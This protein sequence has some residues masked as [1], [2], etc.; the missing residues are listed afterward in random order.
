MRK[1][2]ERILQQYPR[3]YL[4]DSELEA[5]LDGT[6]NSRYSKVKR[7]LAQGKLQHIRRG[8][9]CITAEVGYLKKTHPFELAQYV[10]GPSLISLES[11]L[12]YYHLIPETVY[13][14]TSVSGKRGK[15]FKTPLGLFS[16]KQVPIAN[17]F[18]E[19]SLIKEKDCQFFIAKPWRA[20]CDYIYCYRMDWHTLDP[21]IDSLRMS[22]DQLPILQKEEILLLDEYYHKKRISRFLKKLPEA[23]QHLK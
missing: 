23:L 10:Y 1:S 3:P 22:I 20:I 8:L 18:T 14:I 2:I 11:A 21:L 15:E 4:T 6:P 12:S 17:L 16:F 19:V 9:Y 13:T 7:M 5:L